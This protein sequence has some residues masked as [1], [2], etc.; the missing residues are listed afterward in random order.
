MIANSMDAI[1]FDLDGTL[2]DSSADI[3]Q[4]L[5][6][7]FALSGLNTPHINKNFIGPKLPE[8][9]NSIDPNLNEGEIG[10]ITFHYRRIYD[11][12]QTPRTDLIKGVSIVLNYFKN[13]QV[14]LFIAT[15]KPSSATHPILKHLQ[16]T[17]YFDQVLTPTSI[18]GKE[19]N[20]TEMV[21]IILETNK[22]HTDRAVIVGDHTDDIIAGK[23]NDIKTVAFLGGY[24]KSDSLTK[25][26]PD[27]IIGEMEELVKI[28]G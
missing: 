14:K 17:H 11:S 20:K 8:L 4:S 19:L 22:L 9:I 28:L 1:I 6:K 15:N 7:A 10:N 21:K 24:S 26:N 13:K 16:I 23:K 18:H 2:I 3:I 25:A 12:L 5:E 27:F